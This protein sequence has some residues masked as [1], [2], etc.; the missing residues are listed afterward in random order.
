M[1]TSSTVLVTGATGF[2]GGNLA[3]GLALRGDR[4]RVLL[5]GRQRPVALEGCDYE[6]AE[7]DVR[8]AAA[9]RAA[10]RGCRHVVH[11]AAAVV[12]WCRDARARQAIV[13]INV[14]GTR[15]VLGAAAAERVERVLHV[16][17]VD[18]I[19]L[20]PPGQIADETTAW[21]PGRID[22]IYAE[23][24]R[25]A[26]DVARQA[27]VETVIVNPAFLLGP[28]DPKPSSGRLL[29]PLARGWASPYP[30]RGGNNFVDVRDVVAG[31]L[32]ALDRGRPGERYILGHENLRYQDLFAR[33]LAALGRRPWRVPIP[34]GAAVAAGYVLDAVG[35]LTGRD[36]SL[37][38]EV[39][40]LAYADHYYSAAK[41]V[42]DLGLPQ[43]PIDGALRDAFAWY[44]SAGM[45]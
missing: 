12:F 28:Y 8:D 44:K 13:D 20:P 19:G 37:T 38:S 35:R 34:L 24:K 22:N 29:L 31:A 45:I 15:R 17:T 26:E 33:A 30:T 11:A 1:L 36:P 27:E 6:I 39:A 41:A 10:V 14:E 40:R 2:L 5:R 23:T 7:G 3:R 25:L 16:S 32:A 21:T 43:T 4:V 18:T 9:L 42:R